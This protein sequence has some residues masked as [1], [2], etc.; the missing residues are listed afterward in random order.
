M[1]DEIEQD[2]VIAMDREVEAPSTIHSRLPDVLLAAELLG[3]ERWVTE[4]LLQVTRLLRECATD[5]LG[6]LSVAS[7]ESIRVDEEH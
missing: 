2:A 5:V 7:P 1:G 3:P 4:I 6:S